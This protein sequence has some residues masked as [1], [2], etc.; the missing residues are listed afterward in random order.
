MQANSSPDDIGA[1]V[2]LLYDNNRH[3]NSVNYMNTTDDWDDKKLTMYDTYDGTTQ[4]YYTTTAIKS[5][6]NIYSGCA[7]ETVS[8]V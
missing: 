7:T 1:Y 2:N 5:D 6:G 8:V 3:I 4:N